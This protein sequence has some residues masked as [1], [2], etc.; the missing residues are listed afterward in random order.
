MLTLISLEYCIGVADTF[1]RLA[2]VDLRTKQPVTFNSVL[3]Y[4]KVVNENNGGST[5]LFGLVNNVPQAVNLLV[6]EKLCDYSVPEYITPGEFKEW[7]LKD[8]RCWAT[9]KTIPLSVSRMSGTETH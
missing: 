5:A 9:V 6:V 4:A 2:V 3:N 8:A 7:S 1:K